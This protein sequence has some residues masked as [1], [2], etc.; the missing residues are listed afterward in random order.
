[1]RRR[2]VLA[3][4]GSSAALWPLA[5]RAQPSDRVPITWSLRSLDG[6]AIS[7]GDLA[8]SWLLV[9]FGYTSCPDI[10]PT[11]L[12]DLATVMRALGEVGKRVQPIFITIDPERDTA[13]ILARYIANFDPRLL[14]L[15]GRP[16][17]IAAAAGQF[18]YHYVRYR[19]PRIA[20]YNF[21]HSSAFFLVAPDG[22]LADDFATPDMTPEYIAGGIYRR[23]SASEPR[24]QALRVE[25][26]K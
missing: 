5:G 23:I 11:A 1:M 21:D 6:S 24:S 22:F 7:V 3:M 13:E 8:P 15:T 10:C 18:Q 12:S 4:L 9:Y 16:E 26:S 2:Q 17:D 14:A 20:E 25:R 19:D